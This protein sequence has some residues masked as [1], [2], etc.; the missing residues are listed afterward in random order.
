MYDVLSELFVLLFAMFYF[1]LFAALIFW[2]LKPRL[3]TALR[4]RLRES[5]DARSE[6]AK[7]TEANADVNCRSAGETRLERH[8]DAATI[9]V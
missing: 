8:D 1:I 5:Y 9:F 6:K 2:I 4:K 3:V 7:G